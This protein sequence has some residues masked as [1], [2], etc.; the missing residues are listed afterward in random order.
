MEANKKNSDL[1]LKILAGAS[2]LAVVG[3]M[4]LCGS[5]SGKGKGVKD[6]DTTSQHFDMTDV[7]STDDT[8]TV[9]I[10]K[11]E[12]VRFLA[13]LTGKSVVYL[14]EFVNKYSELTGY[15]YDETVKILCDNYRT[16]EEEYDNLG[17]GMVETLFTK[18]IED[19]KLSIYCDRDLVENRYTYYE[20]AQTD[21]YE[22]SKM[23]E[24]RA[25]QEKIL[26]DFCNDMGM[27][28]DETA[29]SLA[30]FRNETGHGNSPLCV[31]DNNYGGI[32]LPGSNDTYCVYQTPEFGMYMSLNCM[33]EHIKYRESLGANDPISIISSMSERY[34]YEVP[35]AWT[36]LTTELYYQVVED[37][38]ELG[39]AKQYLR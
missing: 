4:I 8:K 10:D 6:E 30:I 31:Y 23:F 29:V 9:V 16:I 1:K 19:E 38:P 20:H 15:S 21:P 7:S 5:L 35:D 36:N 12:K 34:N 22:Q 14:D 25:E 17:E 37:Y 39:T 18:A 28:A 32:K 13:E 11:Y 27:S 3:G 26:I 33:Y 24:Q 2:A